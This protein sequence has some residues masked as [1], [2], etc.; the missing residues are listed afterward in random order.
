MEKGVYDEKAYKYHSAISVSQAHPGI[1]GHKI[2]C[3]QRSLLQPGI[4]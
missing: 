2:E 4:E 1:H 3:P